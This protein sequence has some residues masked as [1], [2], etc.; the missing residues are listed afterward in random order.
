M[1][2]TIKISDEMKFKLEELQAKLLL[3]Q[4]KKITQQDLLEKILSFTLIHA[5]SIF[6]NLEEEFPLEE[7]HAWKTV[8][9]PK[10]WGIKDTSLNPDNYLYGG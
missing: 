2:T 4:K 9:K 3:F 7:D 8:N 5:E 10:K 1:T 6:G